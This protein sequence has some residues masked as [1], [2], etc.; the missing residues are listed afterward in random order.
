M[1]A[2]ETSYT[3]VFIALPDVLRKEQVMMPS[4]RMP[5]C[6]IKMKCQPELRSVFWPV[7]V[8]VSRHLGDHGATALW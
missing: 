6:V 4:V 8:N 5:V 2:L 7:P 1:C 3:D